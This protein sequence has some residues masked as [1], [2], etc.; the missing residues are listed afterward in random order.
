MKQ[1]E[2]N[3]Q[4]MLRRVR[5]H[6]ELHPTAWNAEAPIDARVQRIVNID[7]QLTDQAGNQ[8]RSGGIFSVKDAELDAA[9]TCSTRIATRIRSFARSIQDPLLLKA[10]D[11]SD[12][13]FRYGAQ[14]MRIGHM[15]D[16]L[17]TADQY[18]AQLLPFKV[19]GADREALRT[20]LRR[21]GALRQKASDGLVHQSVATAR[22]PE[23]I[24][25]ARTEL[26]ALDDDVPALVD[27]SAFVEGYFVARRI[28]D[29]R[30]TRPAETPAS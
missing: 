20:A 10:A 24:E 9:A 12:S 27:D 18:A 15:N 23:L 17:E 7:D 3:F 8:R 21:A 29:R 2:S 16:I 4:E 14:D 22:I 1:K 6:F 19:S 11:L 13:D 30:A 25:E 28:T 5:A 26:E